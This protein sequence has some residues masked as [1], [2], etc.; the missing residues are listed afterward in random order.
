MCSFYFFQHLFLINRL[1]NGMS[2]SSRPLRSFNSYAAVIKVRTSKGDQMNEQDLRVK[3][4]KETLALAFIE[5]SSRKA[6]EKITVEALCAEADIQRSTFY[7]HYTDKYDFFRA[8]AK[9]KL[10]A[11]LEGNQQKYTRLH[12]DRFY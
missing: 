3:K 9:D 7:R 12:P 10:I 4:T 5:L 6:F 2:I 11:V 1:N 8:L